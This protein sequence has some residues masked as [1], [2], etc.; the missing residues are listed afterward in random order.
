MNI[1][2]YY[3]NV[4]DSGIWSMN[5]EVFKRFTESWACGKIFEVGLAADL[6]WE[7]YSSVILFHLLS[8]KWQPKY[9]EILIFGCPQKDA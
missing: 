9:N 6:G 7:R 8:H 5:V 1:N 4:L 2:V 3:I